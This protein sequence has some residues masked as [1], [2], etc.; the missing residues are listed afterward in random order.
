MLCHNV[1]YNG[2]SKSCS[3]GGFRTALI[4]PV[5]PLK[6][7]FLAFLWNSD[8]G[9]RYTYWLKSAQPST[10]LLPPPASVP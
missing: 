6:Y 3:T 7:T 5:K 2:K 8:S 4:Y 9:I 10:T 1:L